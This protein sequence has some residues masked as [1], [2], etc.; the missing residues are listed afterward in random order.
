MMSLRGA[1]V[2]VGESDKRRKSVRVNVI[3]VV[4]GGCGGGGVAAIVVR[5]EFD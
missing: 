5:N 3:A 2:C 1:C 4:R